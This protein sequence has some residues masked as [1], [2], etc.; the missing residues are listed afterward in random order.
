L[1]VCPAGDTPSF[2]EQGWFLTIWV[3]DFGGN[4][5]PGIPANDFWLID[6]DPTADAALCGGSGSSNADSITNSDG[7]TTMSL[8]SLVG[9]GCADGMA[10][11]AQG[12]VVA[13][14]ST[15]CTEVKCAPIW[16]RSPDIDGSLRVDLVDLSLFA[17]SYPPHPF[18]R[19]SDLDINGIVNLQDLALFAFHFGPPGHSCL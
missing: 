16:L 19:C 8:T 1:L 6:C 5:I 3:F 13:D 18:D 2:L 17:G 11:V 4:G 10:V 9:G 14:S 12:V 15:G 7:M